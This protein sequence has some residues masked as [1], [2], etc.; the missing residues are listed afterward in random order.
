[1]QMRAAIDR[2]ISRQWQRRGLWAWLMRPLALIYQAISTHRQRKYASGHHRAQRLPVPVIVIGNIYVGGTG[3]TPIACELAQL[4]QAQGWQPGLVSRGYGRH[5]SS[6]PATGRGKDLDWRAFGDEPALI[7]RKTGMAVSSHPQR[8]LAA[9]TLLLQF[10]QTDIIISDDGLQHYPLNRDFEILIQDERGLGN[11]LLLP[12]GPL[13]EGPQRLAQVDLVLKRLADDATP[14][15]GPDTDSANE[16]SFKLEIAAFW[17]PSSD[18]TLSPQALAEDLR[19]AVNAPIV[20]AAGIGVP[21]RFFSSLRALG[22]DLSQTHPL[23]D[24]GPIE[25]DWLKG[26]NARTI[27]ITEKD[28]IKLPLNV[29]ARIWVAITNV[30]W[31]STQAPKR[32]L[33]QLA[34]ANIKFSE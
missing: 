24:H 13:R 30:R 32:I 2:W 12:A 20:A 5:H 11:G 22:I 23:A 19:A 33:E 18:T 28:A 16:L 15:P 1:M 7:A 34:R 6:V 8:R 10:P 14:A 26:L 9:E 29:D 17:H 25:L 31:C 27:L 4:L 3:K 21:E